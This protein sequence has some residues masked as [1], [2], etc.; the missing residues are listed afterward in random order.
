MPERVLVLSQEVSSLAR[1]SVEDIGRVTKTTKMLAINALIEAARAGTVGA[2]FA[3][4]AED[5]RRVSDQI[6]SIAQ[7]MNQQLAQRTA[8]LDELGRTLVQQVRGARLTDLALNMIEIIDRNLYERSCDVRWWATDSA[9][10]DCCTTSDADRAQFCSKRLGVILGAYTV[11]LDIWVCDLDGTVRANGRP[12]KFKGVVGSNVSRQAWFKEAI[13]SRDGS[14]FSAADVD[15]CGLLDD[16]AVSTYG[17]AIRQGGDTNGKPI[18][19]LGIFFDW[20]TQSQ[21]VV[22]GVRLSDDERDRTRCLIVDSGGRIIASNRPVDGAGT[23]SLNT[24]HGT[25]GTYVDAAGRIVGYALTPGYETY[26]GLGWYGVIEQVPPTAAQ[27]A[28]P[29]ARAA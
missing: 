4:V 16:R 5:V 24:Q 15:R 6:D 7:M 2:G 14:A 9:V 19:V 28:S 21:L 20:Q 26:K 27:P 3:V 25:K 23:F 8:A 11:Y 17:C 13:A 22:D 1:Q 29:A 12:D 18:G 10:V